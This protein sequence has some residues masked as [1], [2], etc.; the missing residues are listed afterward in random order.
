MAR[1]GA[2]P[3]GINW[4]QLVP[5]G[6]LIYQPLP[7]QVHVPSGTCQLGLAG[8]SWH[9]RSPAGIALYPLAPAGSTWYQLV[10]VG[11]CRHQLAP[12]F[13][14]WF[15]VAIRLVTVLAAL[16]AWQAPPLLWGYALHP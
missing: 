9:Q 14:R 4:Y 15:G 16:K 7:Y 6:I 10:S 3:A 11:S 5:A 13:R 2:I 8:I 1:A 12:A